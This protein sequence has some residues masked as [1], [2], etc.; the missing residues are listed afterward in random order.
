MPWH[1]S[2]RGGG[3][4]VQSNYLAIELVNR[5]FEV[6]YMVLQVRHDAKRA[7]LPPDLGRAVGRYREG[8]PETS[9]PSQPQSPGDSFAGR[10]I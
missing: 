10:P 7:L 6:H 9:H 8:M 5:G 3:A 2:E 1:I 4:E